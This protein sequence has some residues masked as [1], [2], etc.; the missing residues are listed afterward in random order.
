MNYN[1]KN[2]NLILLTFNKYHDSISTSRRKINMNKLK[3]TDIAKLKKVFSLSLTISMLSLTGCSSKNETGCNLQFEHAHRYVNEETGF[4]LYATSEILYY[5][6]YTRK[7]KFSSKLSF[8]W[9]ED[10][11]TKQEYL[12]DSEV[13]SNRKFL[14]KDNIDA[15]YKDVEKNIP[16]IEY[17]Y[18]RTSHARIG[19]VVTSSKKLRYT[20]DSNHKN[21]TGRIRDVNYQYIAFGN[22]KKEDGSTYWSYNKVDTI[23]ELIENIDKYPYLKPDY[24]KEE[25]YS[26]PYVYTKKK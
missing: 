23:E 7:N 1:S 2:D 26:E 19:G 6:S 17:E 8:M 14:I 21:L 25:K 11:T 3:I 20:T 10:Y 24:Y 13:S 4:S 22:I 5:E 16:Y 15:L 18:E 12:E 9:T